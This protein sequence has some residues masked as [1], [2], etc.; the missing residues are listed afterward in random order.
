MVKAFDYQTF[1]YKHVSNRL[2]FT[3]FGGRIVMSDVKRKFATILAT[4]CVGFSKHML[5]DE[6]ATFE[7]LNACRQIIDTFI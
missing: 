6:E 5:D 1:Y 7:S 4:D 3:N 2:N